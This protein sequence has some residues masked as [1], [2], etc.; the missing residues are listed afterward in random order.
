[1]TL[2]A[3][4]EPLTR[5]TGYRMRHPLWNLGFRPFYLLAS[6]F[7]VF[8]IPFWIVNYFGWLGTA[9]LSS[10]HVGLNWHMHEMVFGMVIA[11]IIGFLYTAG[12]N[13]TGLWTPRHGHLAGLAVLWMAG[14][15]AMLVAGTLPPSLMLIAILIDILFLPLATWPMYRVLRQSGN[16]RNLFLVGLLGLL[17]FA[18][19]IFHASTL[20][21]IQLDPMRSIH[22]AILVIVVMESVIGARVIPMF[23]RNGAPGTTPIVHIGRDRVTLI[24]TVCAVLASIAELPALIQAITAGAA[25][26]AI[27]VRLIGWNPHRTLHV[28]MLWILHLSYAW[29]AIGF[30]LLTLAALNIVPTST[31]FHALAVGSISGLILGMM[32]RT[33]LGHTGRKLTAGRAEVAIYWLIQ[34]GALARVLATFTHLLNQSLLICAAICWSLAFLSYCVSYGPILFQAR[35]DGSEG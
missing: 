34:L 31:A 14:R 20:G 3:I 28:P 5:A 1:M 26:I 15:I 17:T 21:W 30:L 10:F 13:W 8:A 32:T 6:S 23:T 11:V 4:A 27:M 7:A 33:A 25:A 12:K 18:N 22:A 24:L 29:I 2:H 19:I 16:T 9:K 35:I